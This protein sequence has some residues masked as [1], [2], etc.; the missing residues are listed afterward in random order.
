M[1]VSF[2]N[3]DKVKYFLWFLHD[4]NKTNDAF[5]SY[6]FDPNKI[7]T[8]DESNSWVKWQESRKYSRKFLK[9][10]GIK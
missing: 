2:Y 7:D 8:K 1:F 6:T 10:K 3:S 4:L 5:P 9:N